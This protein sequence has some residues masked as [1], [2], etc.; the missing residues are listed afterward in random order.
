ML[1]EDYFRFLEVVEKELN[2]K[3]VVQNCFSD[4]FYDKYH[5]PLKIR[6]KNSLLVEREFEDDR[7]FQGVFIDI[8]PMDYIQEKGESKL[9]IYH[10]SKKKWNLIL[11]FKSRVYRESKA[12]NKHQYLKD[13]LLFQIG[14]LIPDRFLLKQYKKSFNISEG[15][16]IT[17]GIETTWTTLYKVEDILPTKN[18]K[19]EGIEVQ[20]PNNSEG[21]LSKLY[22]Q[23]MVLPPIEERKWHNLKLEVYD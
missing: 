17:Y 10:K 11:R 7:Q 6:H 8:F 20:C 15:N 23:Y 4:S 1:R 21:I 18:I 14:R 9:D 5:I 22:G 3:Y 12:F 19:F 16:Y 2:E 13:I